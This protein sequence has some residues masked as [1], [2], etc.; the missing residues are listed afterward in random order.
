MRGLQ[1]GLSTRQGTLI[2]FADALSRRARHWWHRLAV[3][4]RPPAAESAWR[5][6]L[7]CATDEG[8][9]PTCGR[10][11]VCPGLTAAT[12]STAWLLGAPEQALRW[13][14]RL[15]AWQ[16]PD[17]SLPDA[18]LLHSSLF[19]TAQ[20]IK[21]W[22]FLI[23][24]EQLTEAEPALRRGCAYLKSRIGDDGAMRLPSG[25]GSFDRWA[26]STVH[27][28]GLAVAD[29]WGPVPAGRGSL[30]NSHGICGR[31]HAPHLPVSIRAA[32][33]YALRRGEM[34]PGGTP[35]HVA[36]HGIEA[37]AE[38]G[39]IDDRCA[40]AA[41]RALE[42]LA[43]R[44]RADGS[45][46]VDLEHHWTSSVGLA[47][48]AALWFRT[49]LVEAGNRAITCLE[50]Y[51]RPDGSWPGSWGR[52]A[53]YFPRGTS[54]WTAKYYLDAALEQ[55]S[56]SF[57]GD[58]PTLLSDP[59]EG[60][61]RVTCVDAWAAKVAAQFSADAEVVDV[62]C[63]GGRYLAHLA[64][65]FPQLQLSGIDA[66]AEMLRHV[67]LDVATTVG[68][69]LN[70]PLPSASRDGAVCIE[71]LEHGLVPERA[72]DELCRIVRPGGRVLIIDKSEQF[73]SLSHAQ[74]WERWFTPDE[75][76]GWLAKHCTEVRCTELPEGP[77]QQ[78]PGLFL[79]WEGVRKATS[80]APPATV[81]PQRR[82]A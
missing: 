37:L 1:A 74:P 28:S 38:L 56:A 34:L 40:T 20:A 82:A 71:A 35:T 46:R 36:A 8:L 47:H 73:R 30:V 21:A 76:S 78:T 77:H 63:G 57:A 59:G 15:M 68:G 24:R 7:H 69:L 52:G 32:V 31:V 9:T 67:P 2:R 75:V 44:Q 81:A 60:D 10:S 66:S 62:G 55:V 26:P 79:A 12:V 18:G 27:L 23:D 80:A 17:G 19:N 45:L 50:R 54:V 49:G 29:V 58:D 39:D 13:G 3:G 41:R 25:G 53:A 4:A 11:A 48:L 16:K 5:R 22:A 43:A 61:G 65:R 42:Q 72:V 14:R 64:R 51:L 6:L 70:L 33:E